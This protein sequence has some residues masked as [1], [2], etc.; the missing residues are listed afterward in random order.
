MEE[1]EGKGGNGGK[2]GGGVEGEREREGGGRRGGW[3]GSKNNSELEDNTIIKT[4]QSIHTLCLL[5]W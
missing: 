4:E 5:P 3:R 1:G 2:G